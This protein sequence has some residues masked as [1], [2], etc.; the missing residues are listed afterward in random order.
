MT[1]PAEVA[2][3]EARLKFYTF[4]GGL[5]EIYTRTSLRWWQKGEDRISRDEDTDGLGSSP[6]IPISR[7]RRPR[8]VTPN[9]PLCSQVG[10]AASMGYQNHRFEYPGFSTRSEG[11]LWLLKILF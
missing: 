10:R 2:P 1:V 6:T 3:F 11:Q 9:P 5:I 7:G 8:S 4:D